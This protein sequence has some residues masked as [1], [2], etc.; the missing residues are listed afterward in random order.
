MHLVVGAT[1]LLG[2]EICRRLTQQRH[3]TVGLIRPSSNSEKV[4]G[5]K[6]NGIDVRLGD[7]KDKASLA[8]AC[9]GAKTIVS[10]ASS[11]LSRQAGD[12]I[13][14]VDL[15]GQINL[16]DAARA[17][18]VDRFIYISFRTGANP[19]LKYPLK[20][21]KR[22]VEEHLK[23]SGLTYSILQASYFMEVWLSPALGFDFPNARAT[24][25]GTG[26]NAISWISTPTWLSLLSEQLTI[27]PRGMLH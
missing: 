3:A 23:A 11:T 17:A 25:Y 21:A 26:R 13:Q 24:I 7:L 20:A 22:A 8:E 27:L 14:S 18:G 10:T 6:G 12:T 15:E 19:S 9:R 16:I 4:S 1:G 2:S 5:L